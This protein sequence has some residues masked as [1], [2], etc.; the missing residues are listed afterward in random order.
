M[1]FDVIIGNPPYQLKTEGYG[2]Q[3]KPIYHLFVEHAK[4]LAP[5][6]I[7]MIIPARWFAG[8][9]G[10]DQFRETMLADPQISD[11]VD[12][13]NSADCFPD[14]EIKGGVCYFLWTKGRTGDCNIHTIMNGKESTATRKLN[15]HTV[16]VRFNE[17]ISVVDSVQKKKHALIVNNIQ[18]LNAF[19][20]ETN[21]DG[22][23]DIR[24]KTTLRLYGKKTKA[25]VERATITKGENLIDKYKVL[26]PKAT[27]GSGLFPN[28]ILAKPIVTDKAS[29][30]TMTYIVLGAFNTKAE[31]ENFAGFVSTRFVRF[32]VGLVKNTQDLTKEKFQFV[33]QMDMSQLWY[34]ERL[35][36]YFD[37]TPEGREFIESMI[38]EMK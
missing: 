24:T 38:K 18:G 17:G 14:V 32:L 21:F 35:Y 25:Y 5:K 26:M 33:P 20:L 16:F 2:A 11:I 13:P 19:G 12:Y 10:L 9:M 37:I 8:G 29:V 23:T 27:E 36:A 34:D 6:H 30:C 1:K 28:K 7:C 4:E 31:A 3:A 15:Q 22:G